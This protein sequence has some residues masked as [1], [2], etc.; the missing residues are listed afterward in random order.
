LAHIALDVL[1][2]QVSSVPCERVFSGSKLTATDRRARLKANVF[3][4]LQVLKAAWRREVINLAE[5][6]SKETEEVLDEFEDMFLVDEELGMWD[7][8][9]S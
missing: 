1:P 3:E 4:E 5:H 7:V 8:E 2:S 6:N 9:V